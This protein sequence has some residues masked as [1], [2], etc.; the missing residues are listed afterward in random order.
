MQ[1]L[2]ANQSRFLLPVFL[3][4]PCLLVV[5]SR[6]RSCRVARLE[7]V[8]GKLLS[9][10]EKVSVKYQQKEQSGLVH[11]ARVKGSESHPRPWI[12]GL[13]ADPPAQSQES[14]QEGSRGKHGGHVNWEQRS[15]RKCRF[16]A[17][18]R[19]PSPHG[20]EA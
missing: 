16:P 1:T 7:V 5:W 17:P 9:R 13:V 19:F 11:P 6:V 8:R 3:L 18:L 14:D 10:R 20:E 15:C 4:E 2:H 12:P